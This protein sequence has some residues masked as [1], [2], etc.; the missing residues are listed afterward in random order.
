LVVGLRG[1]GERGEEEEG[2]HEG[3]QA[4]RRVRTRAGARRRGAVAVRGALVHAPA[5]ALWA[6]EAAGAADAVTGRT[7][8][9][10]AGVASESWRRAR[11]SAQSAA[12]MRSAS[13]GK[14]RS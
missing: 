13:V 4:G 5:A 7:T 2:R 6:A 14:R 11:A 10:V 12:A 1:G 8:R 3:A 9:V